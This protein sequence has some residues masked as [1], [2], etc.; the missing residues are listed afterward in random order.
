MVD[1]CIKVER[2]HEDGGTEKFSKLSDVIKLQE[3]KNCKKRFERVRSNAV[4]LR[5]AYKQKDENKEYIGRRK[6]YVD[7]EIQI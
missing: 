5:R 6:F 7:H 3:N 2:T 4:L 1:N